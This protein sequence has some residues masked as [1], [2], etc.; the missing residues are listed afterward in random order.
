[1]TTINF[2]D[3]NG[4]FNMTGITFKYYSRNKLVQEYI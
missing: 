1:M 2:C 3:N 4:H